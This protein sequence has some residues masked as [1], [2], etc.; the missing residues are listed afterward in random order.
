MTALT[1]SIS[2]GLSEFLHGVAEIAEALP[3]ALSAANDY[4][5]LADMTDAQLAKSGL[6]RQD[7]PSF[8]YQRHFT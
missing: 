1:Q 7:L 3:R 2:T 4:S 8:V 6:S 5:R